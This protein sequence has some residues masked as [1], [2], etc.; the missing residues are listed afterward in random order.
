MLNVKYSSQALNFLK[1]CEKDTSERI[2]DKIKLL[3]ENP[4]PKDVKRIE[5][6]REK[7]YRIRVGKNRILYEVDKE[8]N[9][10]GIVKIDK[11]ERVY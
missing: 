8:N 11:R 10:L 7:I 9:L 3:R 1:N 2:L 5:G 4:F 6:Y